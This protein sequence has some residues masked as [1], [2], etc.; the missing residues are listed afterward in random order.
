MLLVIL[1]GVGACAGKSIA[2]GESKNDNRDRTS[3]GATPSTGSGGRPGNATGGFTDVPDVSRGGVPV[4]E[5][6]CGGIPGTQPCGTDAS[7]VLLAHPLIT[8]P[9][10]CPDYATILQSACPGPDVA[11]V[12]RGVPAP[13]VVVDPFRCSCTAGMGWAC[14]NSDENGE[15]HCPTSTDDTVTQT[16]DGGKPATCDPALVPNGCRVLIGGGF[17][18]GTCH[19]ACDESGESNGGA[20]GAPSA[21]WMCVC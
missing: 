4:Y 1:V 9:D 7:G 8:G 3:S 21:R 10:A 14:A 11:C 2:S 5:G 12:Y 17:A 20:A 15:T 18:M 19:C 16:R 13:Y 6:S